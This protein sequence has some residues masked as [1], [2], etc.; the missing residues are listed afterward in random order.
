MGYKYSITTRQT[1]Q[2]VQQDLAETF[3]RWGVH[4]WRTNYPAGARSNSYYQ[5][6]TQRLVELFYVKDG[7]EVH[8]TM[9]LQKRAVDNL[10]VLAIAVESMRLNDVR[11]IGRV[12]ES[13]YMQLAAPVAVRSPYEIL[14]VMQGQELRV[15]EAVYRTM[16][17]KY[18]PDSKPDGDVERFKEINKAIEDIRKEFSK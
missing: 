17:S 12:V 6:E 11:G 16:A 10:R 18:H 3:D 4:D 13:A 9:N 14:G 5:D 1:W 15:Y 2:Q 8:L 7:K